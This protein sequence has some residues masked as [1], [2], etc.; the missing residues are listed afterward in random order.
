MASDSPEAQLSRFAHDKGFLGKGPLCVALVV[1]EHAK[2]HGLPLDARTL[3][4]P[5]GGQVQGLGK[6]AV[7][8]ILRR[9][10]IARVL[11]AE[12]GRT[13]RGS[14]GRMHDYVALLNSFESEVDLA[15]IESFWIDQVRAFFAASP[16]RITLDAS[17]GIRTLVSDLMDQTSR[18]ER[19]AEGMS[20]S[21]AVLQH[22]VGATL[23]C[24]LAGKPVSHNSFSTADA[25]SGRVADFLVGDVAIHVTTA[26][27]E[28]LIGR[29]NENLDNG[30]RPVIVTRNRGLIVAHELARRR[31][32]AERIDVLGIEQ[33]IA[34]IVYSLGGF[35]LA[36]RRSALISI[37]DR[38]NEI[39]R[40]WETDPSLRIA[41]Q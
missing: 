13:S 22:L 27:G 34:V 3:V 7:Q 39:V 5:G 9:H 21:G 33:F 41:Y 10:G 24:R 38:Y 31:S 23:D 29:C 28:A 30:Y 12:G 19:E 2:T 11:A 35:T 16:F 36:G 20:Y 32:V 18:R 25:Q 14:L 26:P 8:S 6:A 1:T 37:V 15:V 17:K 40:Q 4:T